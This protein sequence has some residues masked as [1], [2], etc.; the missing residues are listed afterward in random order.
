MGLKQEM[1]VRKGQ[2]QGQGQE[3][4]LK[5]EMAIHNSILA[6]E[7]PWTEDPDRLQSMRPQKSWTRLSY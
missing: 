7:V 4:L 3:D 2:G 5:K 1:R 6:W